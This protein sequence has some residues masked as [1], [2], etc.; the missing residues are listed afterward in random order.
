LSLPSDA[1]LMAV[2]ALTPDM[3]LMTGSGTPG[4]ACAIR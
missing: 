3:L 2:A 1:V 4:V